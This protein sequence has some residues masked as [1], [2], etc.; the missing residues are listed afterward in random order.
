M[1]IE[2]GLRL[3]PCGADDIF[4]Y[5]LRL[6]AVEK[7]LTFAQAYKEI[8][9]ESDNDPELTTLVWEALLRILTPKEE[10]TNPA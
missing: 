2:G 6:R 1:N 9:E 8:I 3:Y 4:E 10:L 7:G 5:S